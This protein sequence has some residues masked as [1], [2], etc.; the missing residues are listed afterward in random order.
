MDSITVTV[1]LTP[2]DIA[3]ARRLNR[4]RTTWVGRHAS[5][6]WV[7]L[8]VVHFLAIYSVIFLPADVWVGPFFLVFLMNG[9]VVVDRIWLWIRT[10]RAFKHDPNIQR[11]YTVEVSD[12]GVRTSAYAPPSQRWEDVKRWTQGELLYL[13]YAPDGTYHVVPKRFM[14]DATALG[15]VLRERVGP[16]V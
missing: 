12:F 14:P 11:P 4:S 15:E 16:A 2:E 13:I 1:Q 3:Q 5:A 9:Y 6:L 8:L 7:T 10:R